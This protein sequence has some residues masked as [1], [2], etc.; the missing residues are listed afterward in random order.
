MPRPAQDCFLLEPAA[1]DAL[2]TTA[3][4]PLLPGDIVAVSRDGVNLL[5]TTVGGLFGTLGTD[6]IA[7]ESGLD[8]SSPQTLTGALLALSNLVYTTGDIEDTTGISGSP[9]TLSNALLA[10]ET[11]IDSRSKHHGTATW[12]LR[13]L[14]GLT[15]GDS[16]FCSDLGPSGTL[17]YWNGSRWKP[18][19]E[20]PLLQRIGSLATPL[21]A[22]ITHPEGA[23]S[24]KA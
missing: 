9:A 1:A 21:A 20:C 12:A 3:A 19:G 22:S 14:T 15:I 13:P 18:N 11:R 17:L 24:V 6:D 5:Q 7:D 16:F 10:L 23:L 4:G 2:V 8:L